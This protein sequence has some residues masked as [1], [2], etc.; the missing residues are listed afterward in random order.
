MDQSNLECLECL[1]YS[2][3]LV[4]N[5]LRNDEFEN[6]ENFG[7]VCINMGDNKDWELV[8]VGQMIG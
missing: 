2:Q 3:N 5:G 4:T 8:S 7:M 1:N 6:R